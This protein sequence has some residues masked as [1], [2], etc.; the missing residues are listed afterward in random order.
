MRKVLV[1]L[2]FGF[3]FFSFAGKF[4]YVD[5]LTKNI[6]WKT[7]KIY[8]GK[9]YNYS[10]GK[11][12]FSLHWRPTNTVDAKLVDTSLPVGERYISWA[13]Y[14]S[15]GDGINNGDDDEPYSEP[16]PDFGVDVDG[17]GWADRDEKS[18]GMTVGEHD[19][20]DWSKSVGVDDLAV[21]DTLYDRYT[22]KELGKLT[23]GRDK[24]GLLGLGIVNPDTGKFAALADL[25]NTDYYQKGS[26]VDKFIVD[27]PN[28]QE[29]PKDGSNNTPA[30]SG[31]TGDGATIAPIP[32]QN[33]VTNPD[34][35]DNETPVN[36]DNSETVSAINELIW[37]N[38]QHAKKEAERDKVISQQI[39]NQSNIMLD[40]NDLLGDIKGGLGDV[41]NSVDNVANAIND[42]SDKLDGNGQGQGDGDLDKG[43]W[44]NF[45][46]STLSKSSKFSEFKGKLSLPDL[47]SQV[48]NILFEIPAYQIG[49]YE[50]KAMSFRTS[51][52]SSSLSVIR[53]VLITIIHFFSFMKIFDCIG[54]I[55]NMRSM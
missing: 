37:S 34:I 39:Y 20:P 31:N 28:G 4:S 11:V 2:I 47:N 1:V 52:F 33:E 21:G 48:D 38:A 29:Y 16:P 24:A 41:K 17:D 3:S 51:T 53:V 26:S 15:D 46:E 30:G 25:G 19:H 32:G 43:F 36:T 42:L 23:L 12:T 54:S 55:F 45:I 5:T 13:D 18:L 49:D 22:G 14:D 8:G 35:D 44:G 40:G 27:Y 6:V 9:T 10:D 50:F 7:K